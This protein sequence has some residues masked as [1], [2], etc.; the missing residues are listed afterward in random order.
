MD[1]IRIDA[2]EPGTPLPGATWCPELG[3]PS[4]SRP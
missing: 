1:E 2:T 4:W 3:N